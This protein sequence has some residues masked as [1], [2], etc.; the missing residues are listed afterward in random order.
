MECIVD[1]KNWM[2]NNF[3]L[4]NSEKIEV[5][6]IRPKNQKSNN[7]EHYLTLDG[8]SVDSSSLVRNLGG[9]FDS[10]ISFNS[11]FSSICKTEFFSS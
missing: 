11:H 2:T 4:L 10:N 7:L 5:L 3:L 8:C 6:I 9:L 1:I